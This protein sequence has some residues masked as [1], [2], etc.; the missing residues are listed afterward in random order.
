MCTDFVR[1][2]L[3]LLLDLHATSPFGNQAEI[4]M[5]YF[6]L[7]LYLIWNESWKHGYYIWVHGSGECYHIFINLFQMGS[8]E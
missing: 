3:P 6:L 5:F 2:L 8:L 4:T 1:P 7:S